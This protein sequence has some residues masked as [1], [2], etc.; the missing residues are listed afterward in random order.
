MENIGIEALKG[1]TLVRIDVLDNG[2]RIEF[3]TESGERFA[4]LHIQDC[5]EY[6]RVEDINGDV[7]ELIGHPVLVAEERTSENVNPEEVIS[8]CEEESFTWTFYVISTIKE[9]VTIRWL[10]AS[11]G[12]YSESVDFVELTP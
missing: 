1:K 10:G 4:M 9:T 11:N 8:P 5:C 3:E 6:V 2:A 7:D 12:Y